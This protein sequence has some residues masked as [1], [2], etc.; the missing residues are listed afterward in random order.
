[1][2]DSNKMTLEQRLEKTRELRRAGYNCAQC[3]LGAF[4]DVTKLDDETAMRISSGLGAGVAATGET[5]GVV[6]A[7]AINTGL[8][9]N[10]EPATKKRVAMRAADLIGE[11][12]QKHNHLRCC[13]LKG[14]EHPT[15]CNELIEDGVKIFHKHL[16]ESE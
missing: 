14:K 12:Q 5:C 3:V 10:A 2:V 9:D 16:I 11:F 13:E 15:P 4:T 6:S 1:M 7:L 8:M